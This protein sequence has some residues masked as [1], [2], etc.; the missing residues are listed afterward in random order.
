VQHSVCNRIKHRQASWLAVPLAL[1]GLSFESPHARAA[2]G[3]IVDLKIL[4][5][6]DRNEQ[7]PHTNTLAFIAGLNE[8]LVPFK[9]IDLNDPNRDKIDDAFLKTENHA[10]FQAVVLPNE[11]PAQLTET[12]RTTLTNFVREFGLREFDAQ[13]YP[14]PSIGLQTPSL[15]DSGSVDGQEATVTSVGL[16]GP[17]AYLEGPVRFDDIDPTTNHESFVALAE[18]IPTDANAPSN[19]T[20][21]VSMPVPSTGGAGVV[22]GVFNDGSHERLVLTAAMNEYQFQHQVLFPGILNW[23]T[24]GV[25]IGTERNYLAVHVDD[26]F[27]SNDRWDTTLDCTSGADKVNKRRELCSS[28]LPKILMN[29]LDV[30]RLVQWQQ[31]KQFDLDLAFNGAGYDEAIADGQPLAMAQPLLDAANRIRWISH[32]YGHDYLG[33][34]QEFSENELRCVTDNGQTKYVEYE[35]IV[36]EIEGNLGFFTGKPKAPKYFSPVELVTGEHSGLKGVEPVDNPNLAAALTATGVAW[37]G[38]DNSR[39]PQQRQLGENT[40]TLPRYPMNLFYNVGTAAELVDEYNDIYGTSL[41]PSEGFAQTIL[42]GEVRATLLH[43]LLNSPRP[44]YVHQS[45]LAEEQLLYLVLDDVLAQ[46]RRTFAS[47]AG[48]I[49]GNMTELGVELQKQTDWSK[50]S[51]VSASVSGGTLSISLDGQQLDVPLTLPSETE[52]TGLQDYANT[53]TGWH[54]AP[55][56]QQ[57]TLL[58]PESVPYGR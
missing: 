2:P 35:A 49:N 23:L 45:N 16:A 4:V 33:C 58:L 36:A 19:F 18:P 25:H 34:Q 44:H 48:L 20:T 37:I 31:E 10:K 3:Q 42:P 1:I 43:V 46:Y 53:K 7:A 9:E 6:T 24:H 56:G 22:L 12:E 38:A 13:V 14:S 55:A 30:A 39:D 41:D 47:T 17:F 52:Q 32:T 27:R 29:E 15:Q 54:P 57:L 5:V 21:F 11:A 40:R 50:A 26:V 28:E 51:N 8:A